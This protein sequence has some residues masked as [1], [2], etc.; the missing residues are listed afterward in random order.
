M[1]RVV[2]VM[3]LLTLV[4]AGGILG[5]FFQ[6]L[7]KPAPCAADLLPDS[8]LLFLQIPDCDRFAADF[9][10]TRLAAL[11]REPALESFLEKPRQALRDAVR[12]AGPNPEAVRKQILAALQGE[13][14]LAVT[15]ITP[16]PKFKVGLVCGSD[17]RRNIL[18]ARA[19]L[20]HFGRTLRA[21][22]PQARFESKRDRGIA[23]EIWELQPGLTVCH[24]FLNSMLVITLDEDDLR[25]VIGRFTD[26][27]G[28]S[29][30]GHARFRDARAHMPARHALFA[31]LHSESLAGLLAPLL[32]FSPQAAATINNLR[33]IE[34]TSYSLTFTGG[35]AQEITC[36]A[37]KTAPPAAH[38][39]VARRS[40]A[41]TTPNTLLYAVRTADIAAGYQE[42]LD[43]VAQF[44]NESLNTGIA[45]FEHDLRQRGIRLRED[46]LAALGPELA[47]LLNWREG[48]RLPEFALV[49][50]RQPGSDRAQLDTAL[51]AL[52]TALAGDEPWDETVVAGDTL[53][54]IHYGANVLAPTYAVTESYLI[55]ASTPDF[56]RALLGQLRQPQA[57]LATH[58]PYQTAMARLPDGGTAYTY[59]D[60]PV[61]ITR[62]LALGKG[63]GEN[64]PANDYFDLR[65]LPPA[66]I[67][68]KH[69]S[70]YVA[71]TVTGPRHVVTTSYSPIPAPSFVLAGAGLG[72]V[73]AW[74][75]LSAAAPTTSSDTAVPPARRE[76]RTAASQTPIPR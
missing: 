10:S 9:D 56:L 29:L 75:N 24:A 65:Q 63:Y 64:L 67:I 33:S 1:K 62:L 27:T 35:D 74:G 3:L 49:V 32:L 25:A 54:T 40:L 69:L 44:R 57:N 8:T 31:Y 36:I 20:T 21:N 50:E 12:A 48:A 46:V 41:L 5:Y 47:V 18:Q 14:F 55:V 6:T 71:T 23:Y 72:A 22:N 60:L 16:V 7:R 34:T 17:V 52:K 30:A 11:L 2:L 58:P 4:I 26:P 19:W 76:N 37:Y 51:E 45:G 68:A 13:A 28:P 61:L 53:R 15:G 73:A 42:L 66:A 70:P 39:T 38:A 43:S 59:A